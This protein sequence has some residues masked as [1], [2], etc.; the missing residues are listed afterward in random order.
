LRSALG[1]NHNITRFRCLGSSGGVALYQLAQVST[2]IGGYLGSPGRGAV[3]RRLVAG[4]I[5][6]WVMDGRPGY[7]KTICRSRQLLRKGELGRTSRM[8]RI[9]WDT[10]S[11]DREICG[12]QRPAE[13]ARHRDPLSFEHRTGAALRGTAAAKPQVR[14]GQGSRLRHADFL[15]WDEALSVAAGICGSAE[16]Y[17]WPHLRGLIGHLERLPPYPGAGLRPL[18]CCG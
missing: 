9:H 4:G 7:C 6:A 1:S 13:H 17:T 16:K 2:R 8:S 15:L 11:Q 3:I 12:R 14:R 10:S 5:G 18:S